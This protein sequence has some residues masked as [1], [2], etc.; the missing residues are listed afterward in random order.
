MWMCL[1]AP[2]WSGADEVTLVGGGVIEGRIT[3]QSDSGVVLE[4]EDLGQLE[5]RSSRIK[6]IVFDRANAEVV[7]VGGGTIEGKI[8]SQNDAGI[9][10]EHE[11]LGEVDIPESRIESMT[12]DWPDVEIVLVA[13]DT[14]KGK[15]LQQNESAVV[16]EHKNLGRL[17][18]PKA[19][20]RSVVF[21]KKERAWFAPKRLNAWSAK[22]KEEG[23]DVSLDLSY[24]TASGNVKNE[25]SARLG[26]DAERVTKSTRFAHDFSYYNKV[27]RGK[28]TDNK[29]GYR[30][31]HDWLAQESPWFYFVAG[32]YDFDEFMSWQQRLAAYAGPG[33]RLIDTDDMRFDVRVGLGTRKEW[34]SENDDFKFEAGEGLHFDWDVTSRQKITASTVVAGVIGDLDDYR[35]RNSAEWEFSLRSDM[36]LRFIVGIEH[37]YTSVVDPG[38]RH[39][40]TRLYL[41][42]RFGI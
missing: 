20:I 9:T 1:S 4:H 37:E 8:V 42:L 22:L 14:I 26:V 2:S 33:Y 13:G 36:S 28:T 24:N 16:V 18:I 23:W 30:V 17:E 39:S 27:S 3:K 21:H 34:G 31:M 38:D 19:Q 41:G 10:L 40:D 29:L 35:A 7:L 32:Q 15:M 12:V 11:D 5:I 6:S 25:Q